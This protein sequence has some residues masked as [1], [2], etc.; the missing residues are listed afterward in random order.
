MDLFPNENVPLFDYQF[1]LLK[2]ENGKMIYEQKF[3][4][5]LEVLM[6]RF[7]FKG[8]NMI[9]NFEFLCSQKIQI[10]QKSQRISEC[11]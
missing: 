10:K 4:D 6:R 8:T 2:I 11:L 1:F 9:P 7:L 5:L 3:S